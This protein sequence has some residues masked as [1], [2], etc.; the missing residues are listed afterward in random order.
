MVNTTSKILAKD[1]AIN[2]HLKQNLA[3]LINKPFSTRWSKRIIEAITSNNSQESNYNLSSTIE[4]QNSSV[5]N[6]VLTDLKLVVCRPQRGGDA[7][8]LNLH[9]TLDHGAGTGIH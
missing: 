7:E 1:A 9:W 5:G 4:R 8:C 3:T 2:V 6:R